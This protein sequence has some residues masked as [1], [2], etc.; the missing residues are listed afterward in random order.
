MIAI[1]SSPPK[2]LSMDRTAFND[3]WNVDQKTNRFAERMGMGPEPTAVT[4][5]HDAMIGGERSPNGSPASAFFLGGVWRYRRTLDVSPDDVDTCIL[6]EFE[7]VYRDARVFVNDALAA[8]RPYG[9]SDFVVPIDPLLRFGESNEIRVE[10]R[11]HEDSRWYPGAGIHRNVW[12]LRAGRIH[13]EPRGLQVTTPELDDDIAVVSVAI[14]VCNHSSFSST[15]VVAVELLD[16]DGA[17][18]A[19]SSAPARRCQ[20]RR[21]F[22]T[23]LSWHVRSGGGLVIRTCTPAGSGWQTRMR[24]WT[25]RQRRSA[26]ELCPSTLCAACVSTASRFCCAARVSTMTTARSAPVRSTEPR[27]GGSRS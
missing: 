12:L 15:A 10:A 13:V 19:Q 3:G 23:A 5:P 25:R 21:Q 27:S 2:I 20:G 9:Y 24:L 1:T 14:G 16:A 4:L 18:V 22:A 26:C 7:G 11:V 8:H 6:L 17:V